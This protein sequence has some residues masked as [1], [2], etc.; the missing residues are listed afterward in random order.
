MKGANLTPSIGKQLVG[1]NGALD[2]LI[3][4]F[5]W[6]IL[7]VDFFVFPVGELGGNQAG[8]PR[9]QAEL[10]GRRAD[11]RA[12]L[13]ANNRWD[14]WLGV[15]LPSPVQRMA[16]VYAGQSRLDISLDILRGST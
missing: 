5:R 11:S 4:I 7:S 8:M 2:Y 3:D 1:P 10:I 13:G 16:N 14:E 12:D 9:E 6:L 15:H